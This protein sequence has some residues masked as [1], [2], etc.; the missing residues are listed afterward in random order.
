[1][2]DSHDTAVRAD[3]LVTGY[4]TRRGEIRTG[5]PFDAVL[6]RGELCCLLGPNG[7]GKST[8]LRTLSGFQQPLG[9]T[10]R[11]GGVP[12]TSMTAAERARAVAV[13]LTERAVV[14]DMTARQLVATGRV[15]YT[16]F[17]GNLSREDNEA[18]DRAL[19]AA[20][21]A[22]LAAR[23]VASLSDG[24]RQKV[25]IA[26]ALAQDTPVILLDE[27]TAFLDW[28]G[29]VEATRLLRTLAREG[30]RAVLLATHDLEV[31]LQLADRLWLMDGGGHLAAGTPAEL[32][33]TGDIARCLTRPGTAY[34]PL[35][36]RFRI[37]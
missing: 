7:S 22:H 20:G 3:A 37:L 35:Q 36:S 30:G 5:G 9:G 25:M 11:I 6:K 29:K 16:G 21:A 33:A 8:L 28:P 31:A 23:E 14:D 15:P 32:T 18:V 4:R 17:W 27:P 2:T 26:R 13:V 10:V 24:E 34:D 19:S 1:M 12:L